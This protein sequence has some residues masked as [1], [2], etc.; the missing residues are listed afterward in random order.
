MAAELITNAADGADQ[1]TV[2]LELLAQV[3]HVDVDRAIERPCF[4]LI[5]RIHQ[6]IAR[7]HPSRGFH[8]C[9]KDVEFNRRQLDRLAVESHGPR[10]RI[11][12][13]AVHLDARTSGFARLETP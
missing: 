5:D 4:A 13:Y 1:R 11:E 9:L 8:E 2:R 12:P 10:C 7:E 6:G 3:A